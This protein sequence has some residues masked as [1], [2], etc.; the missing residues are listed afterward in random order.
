MNNKFAALVKSRPNLLQSDNKI[1]YR[2]VPSSQRPPPLEPC[3]KNHSLKLKV[4]ADALQQ[5]ES[6]SD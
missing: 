6:P 4:I 5:I 3:T 1:P 2:D